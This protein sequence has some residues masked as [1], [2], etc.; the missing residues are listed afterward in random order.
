M[1]R[2]GGNETTRVLTQADHQHQVIASILT[3]GC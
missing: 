1:E 3:K 2:R